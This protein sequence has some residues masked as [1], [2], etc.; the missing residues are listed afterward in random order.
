VPATLAL[1]AALATAVTGC[2]PAA[3]A[4][5]A[6]PRA[7]TAA[8]RATTAVPT[9][10]A[11]PT[12]RPAV[13]RGPRPRPDRAR[14]E[15]SPR[16][17]SAPHLA[18]PLLVERLVGVGD[19]GQVLAVTADG[20]GTTYATLTAFQR[21]PSGWRQ[22]FGPWTARIG[23]NGFAPAGDK[24]EGDGRTPTGSYGFQFFFGVD[25]APA[26]IRYAYRPALTTSYWDDDPA[27][28]NYNE[29]VDSRYQAT[30]R[31]PE[32]MHKVPAYLYSAVIA[33]NS[34]RTPGLGSAIFLHVDHGS[35]TAGCVAIDE[36]NLLRVLRWLDPRDRPRIIM[37]TTAAVTR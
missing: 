8:S 33:Y 3:R 12:L 28:P 14:A 35:A 32:S 1:V 21:T 15:Q 2:G 17:A 22:A 9:P 37:G 7:T 27:S 16:A 34:A 13:H 29:W 4:P 10:P 25:P 31:V 26:G 23:Y 18:G 24:R 6:A 36:S 19:A 20:Y 5:T 30:G 11:A